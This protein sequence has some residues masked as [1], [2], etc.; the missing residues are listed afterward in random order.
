M[1]HQRVCEYGRWAIVEAKIFF[2]P[3]YSWSEKLQYGAKRE[4]VAS[5]KC[6]KKVFLF[7]YFLLRDRDVWN[8]STK[9]LFK[10]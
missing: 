10:I 9:T 7:W 5:K 4:R 8:F 1:I 2:P 3:F 6:K